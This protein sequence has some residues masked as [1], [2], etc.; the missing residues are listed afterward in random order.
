MGPNR[1]QTCPDWPTGDPK[2]F[3]LTSSGLAA[4]GQDDGRLISPNPHPLPPG[5]DLL[6]H[7]PWR[8]VPSLGGHA[9]IPAGPFDRSAIDCRS[10]V[11]TYTTAPCADAI[12]VAG[13][14]GV[15]LYCR[16]DA[17]SFDI[18]AIVSVVYPDGRVMNMT[19]G[20]S[21]IQPVPEDS[22]EAMQTVVVPLQS[23]CFTI[24]A[25]HALR[26][27]LAAACFPAY[28]VNAGT[29]T[30][31]GQGRL[32]DQ[33]IITLQVCHGPSYPSRLSL[34]WGPDPSALATPAA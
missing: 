3:Y 24:P 7:D 19:Q 1:W 26:L 23:T 2:H 25:H 31:P 34:P 32:I 12:Q 33:R 9:G 22:A 16:A 21:W 15:R 28:A 30:H 10:D 5:V 13:D 18:S 8:P 17:P 14:G 29:G 11:L 4:M 6:V 20:H 27:S